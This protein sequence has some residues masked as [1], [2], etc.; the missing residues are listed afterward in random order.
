MLDAILYFGVAVMAFFGV[1]ACLW[2][3]TAGKG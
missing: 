2:L 1:L 3:Y